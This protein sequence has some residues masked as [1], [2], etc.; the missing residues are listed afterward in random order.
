MKKR[1]NFLK[2]FTLKKSTLDIPIQMHIQ[3]LILIYQLT[4]EKKLVLSEALVQVKALL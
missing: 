4:L 3:L 1:S 2:I